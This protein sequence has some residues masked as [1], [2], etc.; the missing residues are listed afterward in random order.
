MQKLTLKQLTSGAT[1][2]TVRLTHDTN[3]NKEVINA[4]VQMMNAGPHTDGFIVAADFNVAGGDTAT[5]HSAF[6]GLVVSACAIA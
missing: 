3:K 1:R 6:D 5:V 2:E 4:M